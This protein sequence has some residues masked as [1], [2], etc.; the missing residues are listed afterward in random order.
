MIRVR[1]ASDGWWAIVLVGSRASMGATLE[2]ARARFRAARN[3]AWHIEKWFR[4]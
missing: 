1:R 2:H 4:L 3:E